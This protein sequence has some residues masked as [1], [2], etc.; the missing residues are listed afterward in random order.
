MIWYRKLRVERHDEHGI[1]MNK[2]RSQPQIEELHVTN[3]RVLQEVHFHD[4]MRLTVLIGPNG[5]GKSTVFDVL[6]FLSEAFRSGLR[7]AWDR[8]GRAREL[9]TRGQDGP[10]FIGLKYRE[11]SRATMN[12]YTIRIDEVHGSPVVIDEKLVM[13]SDQQGHGELILHYQSGEGF[14][15]TRD[16]ST[17][18]SETFAPLRSPELIAVSSLGQLASHPRVAALRE[19]IMD[20]HV[21]YL[22]I[23]DTHGQSDAGP[24]EHLSETGGNLAN[25]IQYLSEQHPD[26]LAEIFRTLSRRVPLLEKVI[27]EE[28][29]DGRLLLLI[30]DMPFKDPILARFASDGTLKLLA[31]LVLLNLPDPPR[32]IGIEEPEN[33]LHPRLMYPLAEEFRNASG[34]SQLL[35]TTHSPYFLDALRPDEVHVLFRDRRGYTQVQ[36]ASD[37][38]HVKEFMEN[39]GMLGDLWME[40]RFHVGDPL[41]SSGMPVRRARR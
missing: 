17:S 13:N 28:L 33:Y 30:K 23:P 41:T 20:W 6:S 24:Q 26:R 36:R 16:S 21:S 14:V 7:P 4:L 10:L 40:G 37:I 39:G 27:P 31:Y 12:Y 25:V 9:K 15:F 3:Y 38:E 2:P 32:F 29:A 22:S 1:S 11:E 35:A 34:H 8:R 18:D 19:F 5:S